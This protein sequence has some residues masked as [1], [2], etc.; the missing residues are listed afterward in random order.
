MLAFDAD[1][2]GVQQTAVRQLAPHWLLQFTGFGQDEAVG[3]DDCSQSHLLAAAQH[4]SCALC[5]SPNDFA[6]R[7][8]DHRPVPSAEAEPSGAAKQAALGAGGAASCA[9]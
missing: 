4:L 3:A 1:D 5:R 7:G 2:L 9:F 8:P 6:K